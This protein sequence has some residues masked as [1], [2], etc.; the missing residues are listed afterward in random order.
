LVAGPLLSVW[1]RQFDDLRTLGILSEREGDAFVVRMKHKNMSLSAQSTVMGH[2]GQGRPTEDE[3]G[4]LEKSVKT[5]RSRAGITAMRLRRVTLRRDATEGEEDVVVLTNLLDRERYS[6]ADILEL[7][8]NRWSI[9]AVFQQVTETFSLSHLMGCGPR[10]VI[11]QFA[12]CLLLYNLMQVIK[13]YVAQD[14]KVLAGMVSMHYLFI[15]TSNELTA[16]ACHC[17]GSWPWGSVRQRDAASLRSRLRKLLRGSWHPI[18]Y[19]K[20]PDRKPRGKP[21]PKKWLLGGHTSVQRALEGRVKV[22]RRSKV[23]VR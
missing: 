1:D 19:G 17:E 6:A 18:K 7:Y 23:V 11:L 12:F 21:K 13:L 14:G 8:R 9:E 4:V 15:A 3:I 20:R 16:W 22:T 5:K 10:A 2:D